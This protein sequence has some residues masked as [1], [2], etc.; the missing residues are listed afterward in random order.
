MIATSRILGVPE[1]PLMIP[2]HGWLQQ[3]E[4]FARRTGLEQW[5]GANG[6]S[7]WYRTAPGRNWTARD[8]AGAI[9]LVHDARS[10]TGTT[11]PLVL[12]GF[13]DGGTMAH[14]AGTLLIAAG[15]PVLGIWAH[16]APFPRD[17]VDFP[18][19]GAVVCVS[20]NASERRKL[21]RFGLPWYSML[22]Y[23]QQAFGWYQDAGCECHMY[24]G[25][26]SGHRWDAQL[27]AQVL[28][29]ICR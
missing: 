7:C 1:K 3:G 17:L 18:P 4:N 2:F 25:L 28:R 19:S 21:P 29:R 6:W 27:N 11:G 12:V 5:C 14:R 24:T 10:E 15:H 16:S 13:S 20:C 9:G 22:D 26:E 23:R 8:A